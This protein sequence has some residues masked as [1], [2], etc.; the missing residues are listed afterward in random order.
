MNAQH[1]DKHTRTGR[2]IDLSK[3]DEKF[4]KPA[5]KHVIPTYYIY[6]FSPSQLLGDRLF[7]LKEGPL[8]GT[9]HVPDIDINDHTAD[10]KQRFVINYLRARD[11]IK[12]WKLSTSMR[13]V[14]MYTHLHC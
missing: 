12:V 4:P 8:H 2:A 9:P 14:Y 6:V 3:F 10:I 11:N 1:A 13:I 5:H 7:D